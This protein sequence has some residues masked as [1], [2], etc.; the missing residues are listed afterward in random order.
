[1]YTS[2]GVTVPLQHCTK[3]PEPGGKTMIASPGLVSLCI[4]A[5]KTRP[6]GKT[7]CTSQR[8][9]GCR[10]QNSDRLHPCNSE[11]YGIIVVYLGYSHPNKHLKVNTKRSNSSNQNLP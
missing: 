11:E 7:D 8:K 1:M 9:Q 5:K 6:G 2:I 4:A 10:V 3:K